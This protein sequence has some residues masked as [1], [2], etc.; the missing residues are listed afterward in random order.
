M[1]FG[2]G[3][4]AFPLAVGQVAAQYWIWEFLGLVMTG[5]IL[6]FLGL[7]VIEL[8]RGN[9]S[10]FFGGAGPFVKFF[11][12]LLTLSLLGSFGAVP[13]CVTV[14]YESIHYV[15][16]YLSK[17]NFSFIFCGI[18]FFVCLKEQRVINAIGK[19]LTPALLIF[20]I[21]LTIFGINHAKELK[22][23]N[24]VA[25][26]KLFFDGLI[27]GYQTMDL[28]AAFFFSALIFNQIKKT[29]PAKTSDADIMKMAIKSSIVA[30]LLLVGAYAG[31]AFLGANFSGLIENVKSTSILIT[32]ANHIMGDYAALFVGITM[33]IACF[34]TTVALNSIYTQYLCSLIKLDQERFKYV[35][36]VTTVIAFLVSLFDFDE[37]AWI[38]IPILEITYPS[39]IALTIIG[40]FVRKQT[41]FKVIL[42]YGVLVIALLYEFIEI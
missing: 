27:L 25:P 29:F 26:S 23:I 22:E 10:S 18:V 5:V 21:L 37:I 34:A 39:L 20:I 14:A 35:L 36:L 24:P 38:L 33:V 4:L 13:W 2:A 15:I 9:Y 17:A 12:P 41:K 7:F 42:F 32:I 1:F 6:P 19:W 8:H 3:N 31:M 30:V 40:I 16:P 11:L 28:L